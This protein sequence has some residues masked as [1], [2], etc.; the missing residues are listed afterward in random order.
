MRP[1]KPKFRGFI[2]GFGKALTKPAYGTGLILL[3]SHV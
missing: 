3:L 1:V 2:K